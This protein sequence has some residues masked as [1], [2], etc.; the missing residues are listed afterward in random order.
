MRLQRQ[1][2]KSEVLPIFVAFRV[3][4]YNGHKLTIL[5]RDLEHAVAV[6]I[7][8][9]FHKTRTNGRSQA[10]LKGSGIIVKVAP[11]QRKEV[12]APGQRAS[13]GR[14]KPAVNVFQRSGNL[15]VSDRNTGLQ[16]AGLFAVIQSPESIGLCRNGEVS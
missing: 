1:A 8:E 12:T 14:V 6:R 9:A 13:P 2:G 15:T 16:V 4:L 5:V 7:A 11:L 10:N 3:C